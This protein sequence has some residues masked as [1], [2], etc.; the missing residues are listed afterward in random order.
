M[1][2]LRRAWGALVGPPPVPVMP[3][4]PDPD[5]RP[6]AEW[7]SI[8]TARSAA[9]LK[10]FPQ[11]RDDDYQNEVIAVCSV[12]GIKVYGCQGVSFGW[13]ED[14]EADNRCWEHRED[15]PLV[16]KETVHVLDR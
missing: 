4:L 3:E 2:I 14:G 1:S 10:P 8:V 7:D 9:G 11:R 16:L 6:Q 12:C 13:T 5:D 15:K